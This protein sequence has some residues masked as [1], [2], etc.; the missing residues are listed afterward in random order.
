MTTREW[1]KHAL[2]RSI[3]RNAEEASS[4]RQFR[5]QLAEI[6]ND[7]PQNAS[8][9]LQ[10]Y[11]VSFPHSSKTVPHRAARK[12]TFIRL[13]MLIIFFIFP[14]LSIALS[15]SNGETPP[16]GWGLTI[17]MLVFSSLAVGQTS[18]LSLEQ[19]LRPLR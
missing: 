4:T 2:A 7:L 12:A 9:E 17:G 18:S 19:Q 10:R 3:Q 8:D 14:I 15:L 6:A 5:R 1:I 16:G 13:L 11:Q